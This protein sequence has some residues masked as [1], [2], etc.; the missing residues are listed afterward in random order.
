MK[1]W[2]KVLVSATLL[3][4]LLVLLPWH[5]VREALG[6]L[7][8]LV[9]A[10]VLGCFLVGHAVGVGKWRLFVNAGRA[11]LGRLDATLCYAA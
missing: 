9:W 1:V 7:P 5:Q 3:A 2:V 6:R 10:G 8:P 11:G 4:L